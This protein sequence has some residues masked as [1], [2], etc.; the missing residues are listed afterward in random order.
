M[1]D[2]IKILENQYRCSN[3]KTQGKDID[4]AILDKTKIPDII[5]F[6]KKQG[7][8]YTKKPS[9]LYFE[10]NDIM[11]DI[12][13]DLDYLNAWFYD[14]KIN[15]NIVKKYFHNPEKYHIPISSLRYILLLRK[16]KKYI[17]FL[18][19]NKEYL[20]KNNFFLHYLN[21]NPFSKKINI[22]ILL[23]ILNRDFPT[24]IKNIKLKYL[25]YFL[26]KKISIILIK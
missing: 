1:S 6:L 13:T 22:N 7:F 4:I 15:D 21:K 5:F 24:I 23:K 3:L 10:K 8:K 12:A 9:K 17:N 19:K 16:Q 18:I 14:I 26:C 25:I 20:Q 2:I 11:L